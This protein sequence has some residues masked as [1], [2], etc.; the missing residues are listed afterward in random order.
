M[1][2]HPNETAA[3][4]IEPIQG[5]GGFITPPNDFLRRLR[6][7]CDANGMLLIMDEVQSGAGRTG[8]WWAHTQFEESKPDIMVFA[9]GICSG[10]PFAG[11]ATRPDL[12]DNMQPGS[13]VRR[14][15]VALC[16]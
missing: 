10:F 12:Y 5:E 14:A 3:V 6:E 1:Q 4:I 9:K 15:R 7:L 13:M 16:L 11:L 2:T 8:K